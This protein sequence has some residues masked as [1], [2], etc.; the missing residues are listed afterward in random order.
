VFS[1]VRK[2]VFGLLVSIEL[3][4]AGFAGTFVV[5]TNYEFKKRSAALDYRWIGADVVSVWTGV[6]PESEAGVLP[7]ENSYGFGRTNLLGLRRMVLQI[8]NNHNPVR[9]AALLCTGLI[10]LCS[11]CT[12]VPGKSSTLTGFKSAVFNERALL[13]GGLAVGFV[14]NSQGGSKLKPYERH[15]Y[16]DQLASYILRNNPGLHGNIDSYAYVSARMGTV[17]NPFLDGFRL[18]GELGKRA[19]EQVKQASLRRRFLML[20]SI[21]PVDDTLELPVTVDSVE[22]ISNPELADY[23]DV[24][25][26]TARLKAVRLLVY[27]T[28]KGRRVLD[29]VYSSGDDNRVFA[30]ERTGRRYKGNSLLGA[31]ANSVSNRVRRASDVNHPPPPSEAETLKYIWRRISE[32]LPGAV[33]F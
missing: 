27:D 17:F 3:K 10:V 32:S 30:T 15:R 4:G 14:V 31:L 12:S 13:S 26:Q 5:E 23:E 33:T 8:W 22:G 28:V 24:R 20:A 11:S 6:P 9:A 1:S 2:A 7:A 18:E 29:K 25:F 21:Y 19:L 16:A